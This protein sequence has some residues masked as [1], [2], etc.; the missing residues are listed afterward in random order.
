[1]HWAV[2]SRM[3]C[4]SLWFEEVVVGRRGEGE[5]PALRNV[6]RVCRVVF[7]ELH[8]CVEGEKL[9]GRGPGVK[10]G[11]K[12]DDGKYGNFFRVLIRKEGLKVGMLGHV[13]TYFILARF[14]EYTSK[15]RRVYNA[16]ASS[17]NTVAT[18]QRKCKSTLIIRLFSVPA[19]GAHV[20]ETLGHA[21][22]YE[23]FDR[24]L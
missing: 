2:E 16:M 19:L 14:L 12:W 22:Q 21:S 20:Y 15:S 4:K 3:A 11:Q 6:R 7:R 24:N 5:S 13:T 23:V 9:A 18:D 1:M 8:V 10:A 17:A